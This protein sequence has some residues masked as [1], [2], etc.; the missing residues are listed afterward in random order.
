MIPEEIEKKL[1]QAVA[2]IKSSSHTTVFTGAGVSVES[3][4]PPFRG[5]DGLWSSID[6]VFLDTAYF[7]RYPKESWKLIKHI[8]YDFFGEAKPNQAHYA[9][10]QLEEKQLLHTVIT[11]NIDNLHQAAGSKDV[12][13]FHGTSRKLMCTR[14]ERIFDVTE[15][16]LE[17]LPPLCQNCSNVLK[18]CFVFFGESIPEEA[19]TRSLNEARTADTFIVIG[20][21]GEIQPASMIPVIA[22]ENGV[23]IIE[24]NIEASRYTNSITDIFLKGKATEIMGY[25]LEH[26]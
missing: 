1:L 7:S 4:I 24:I 21:T 11:Q 8:F 6:P 9:L 18:P 16:L 15:T 10:A 5:K 19:N 23:K 2:L 22:K 17:N 3:G 26:L 20:T 14:C 25:L 13:E 12:I